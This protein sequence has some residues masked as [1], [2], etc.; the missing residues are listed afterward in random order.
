MNLDWTWCSFFVRVFLLAR[1]IKTLAAALELRQDIFFESLN[2]TQYKYFE[3]NV[4]P[5]SVILTNR[6]IMQYWNWQRSFYFEFHVILKE[7]DWPRASEL[8]KI[9]KS[10]T[11]SYEISPRWLN[12]LRGSNQSLNLI[13]SN[14]EIWCRANSMLSCRLPSSLWEI[15]NQK[16][17]K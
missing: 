6:Y 5:Q 2:S 17:K 10:M 9:T 15:K 11:N 13:E 3:M 14:M 4:M 16:K 7:F 8:K 12:P 1:L